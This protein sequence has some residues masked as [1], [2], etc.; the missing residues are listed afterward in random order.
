MLLYCFH[1]AFYMICDSILVEAY[2]RTHLTDF[3]GWLFSGQCSYMDICCWAF[4]CIILF[5][6]CIR[7][8]LNC[9][10]S[11]CVASCSA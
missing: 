5:H 4:L 3:T 9:R 11:V 10:Q 6:V 2:F 1:I 8:L 7:K